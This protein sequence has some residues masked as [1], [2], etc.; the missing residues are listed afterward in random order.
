MVALAETRQTMTSLDI[1]ILMKQ[2]F[3]I[4]TKNGTIAQD[5]DL[6]CN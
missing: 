5:W 3:S 6:L 1:F 2:T 4:S